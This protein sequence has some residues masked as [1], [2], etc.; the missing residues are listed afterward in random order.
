M[1][2]PPEVTFHLEN[3]AQRQAVL[4]LLAKWPQLG[5]QEEPTPS[6]GPSKHATVAATETTLDSTASPSLQQVRARLTELSRAGKGEA[7]R[8]LLKQFGASTLT[9]L[10]P[11]HYRAILAQ[12]DV[13]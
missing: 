2:T 4:H 11:V 13:L 1:P 5:E 8:S 10:N 6:E 12:G 7:I 9:E 3:E